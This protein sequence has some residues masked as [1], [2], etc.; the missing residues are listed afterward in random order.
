MPKSGKGSGNCFI[1][2]GLTNKT[3]IKITSIIAEPKVNNCVAILF[4]LFLLRNP[5]ER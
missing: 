2:N 4:F 1:F 5:L 3:E